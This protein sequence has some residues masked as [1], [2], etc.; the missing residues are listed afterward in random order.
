MKP[1]PSDVRQTA[2]LL[3]AAYDSSPK[4]PAPPEQRQ[5]PRAPMQPWEY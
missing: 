4:A 5:Q 3:A 2:R 1:R